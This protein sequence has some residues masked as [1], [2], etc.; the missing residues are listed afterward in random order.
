[1]RDRLRGV[2]LA[3]GLILLVGGA[4]LFLLRYRVYQ[5]PTTSMTPAI[6]PADRI[7]VDTWSRDARSGDVVLIAG[8]G[9]DLV[10]RVA[11]T[12]G[13]VVSC[14]DAAGHLQT[15]GVA[16]SLPPSGDDPFSVRV[17]AGQLF[18]LGDNLP[19]SVD[20]R[21]TGPDA[22]SSVLGRVVALAYPARLFPDRAAGTLRLVCGT[23]LLGLVLVLLSPLMP[24]RRT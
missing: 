19:T 16:L 22:T 14:C 8:N 3:T 7:V 21:A 11:A 5:V 23:G 20:S 12:A 17:P 1:M 18:L 9:V 2:F 6:E 4:G 10:K 13:D 15:G 24:S